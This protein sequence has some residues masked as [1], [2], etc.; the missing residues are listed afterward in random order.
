MRLST[1]VEVSCYSPYLN[2]LLDSSLALPI[3]RM[4]TAEQDI[5]SAPGFPDY[6]EAYVGAAKGSLEVRPPNR[7]PKPKT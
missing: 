4:N 1:H 7:T 6:L 5:I 3:L 2:R